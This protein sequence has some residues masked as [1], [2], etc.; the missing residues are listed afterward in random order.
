MGQGTLSALQDV[1]SASGQ[2]VFVRAAL[3]SGRRA[4]RYL[5]VTAGP[6]A[7]PPGW[8]PGVWEYEDVCFIAAPASS[9]ALAGALDPYD[10]QVLPLGGLALT[11]PVLS[12]QLSWQHK[13]SRAR[14]DSVLLPWPALI[15][16][17]HLPGGSGGQQSPH[18]F[19]IGDD[20]PSF[21]SYDA[22]FRAFFYGDFSRRAAGNM[23]RQLRHGAGRRRPG[24]AGPGARY[25]GVAGRV[26][27]RHR[28]RRHQGR[29]Q[30]R[31]VP[32]RCPRHGRPAR[33]PCRSRMA[34]PRARGCT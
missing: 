12:G 32:V 34:C 22:A 1:L 15:C 11:L 24:V 18:G 29:A 25:P 23:P 26:P 6:P 33:S 19:L 4:V 16:E 5:D 21:P 13:P 8:E 31:D 27:G 7:E 20:C 30:R 3:H 9:R 17:L 2:T 14:F 28:G 10:A